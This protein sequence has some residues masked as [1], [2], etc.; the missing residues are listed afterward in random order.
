MILTS[1]VL[2]LKDGTSTSQP[3]PVRIGLNLSG[4]AGSSTGR[5]HAQP[6][7][8]PFRS[9]DGDRPHK[10]A[11]SGRD[12]HSRPASYQSVGPCGR[13]SWAVGGR[14]TPGTVILFCPHCTSAGS[15]RLK[16]LQDR[17]SRRVGQCGT[18]PLPEPTPRTEPS[19]H[20]AA[21]A[22]KGHLRCRLVPGDDGRPVA[23]LERCIFRHL[24]GP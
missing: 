1:G 6:V 15:R 17:H 21:A 9:L 24:P 2:E 11:R 16:P 13:K 20:H 8:G 18:P 3:E 23:R 10:S 14:G 19:H 22:L 5:G 4:S 7:C 12:R